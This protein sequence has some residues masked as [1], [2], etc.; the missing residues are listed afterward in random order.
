MPDKRSR[1]CTQPAGIFASS[2]PIYGIPSIVG[3]FHFQFAC[4]MGFVVNE[5]R[6]NGQIACIDKA[7]V[8]ALTQPAAEADS[9]AKALCRDVDGLRIVLVNVGTLGLGVDD[10]VSHDLGF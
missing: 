3:E 10:V 6:C 8:K 7:K 9:M 5:L 1:R 2:H 4:V